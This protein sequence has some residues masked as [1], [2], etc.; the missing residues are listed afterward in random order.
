M[1]GP[2]ITHTALATRPEA[3]RAYSVPFQEGLPVRA[4]SALADELYYHGVLTANTRHGI[5]RCTETFV[6]KDAGLVDV[7]HVYH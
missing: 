2:I 6:V 4:I 7:L 3:I 5:R 1:Q